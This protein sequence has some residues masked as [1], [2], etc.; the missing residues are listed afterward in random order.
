VRTHLQTATDAACEAAAQA[1]DAAAFRNSGTERVNLALGAGYAQR[2]FA[3]TVADRALSA[4]G[5][6]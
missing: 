2:E 1:I 5:R 4:T 6:R 3:A